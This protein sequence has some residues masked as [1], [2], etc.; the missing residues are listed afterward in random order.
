MIDR[1]MLS[2]RTPL[3]VFTF[4]LVGTIFL[5]ADDKAAQPV[6]GS[7]PAQTMKPQAPPTGDEIHIHWKLIENKPDGSGQRCLWTF[8]NNGKSPLPANGWAIYFCQLNLVGEPIVD[9]NGPFELERLNGDFF[10]ITPKKQF[11]PL[12]PGSEAT[13]GYQGGE[14]VIKECVAPEGIY[15]VYQKGDGPEGKP[16]AIT[17][18]DIEPFTR[19]EQLSRSSKDQTPVPTPGWQYEQ[20]SAL[21]LLPADKVSRI[22]PTP[23]HFESGQGE[24]TLSAKTKIVHG[25]GFKREAVYLAKKLQT[26]FGT[27]PE[28]TAGIEGGADAIMLSVGRVNID[29][30]DR[31][32]GSEAYE[33]SIDPKTG[34]NI[35]GSDD[36]GAFYGIQSLLALLPPQAFAGNQS[37][38]KVGAAKI[39]DAPRF[40]YRGQ[41]LEVC[42]NFHTKQSVLRLL[43]L[44]AFYKLNR[45][46]WHLSDDE[47]WRFEIPGLPELTQYH[48]RRG[49]TLT[50]GE[51]LHPSYGSGPNPAHNHG[52]GYYS[53]ADM[54]EVLRRAHDLHILVIPEIDMPAHS[55]AAIYAMKARERRLET[56]SKLDE[57]REY[58]L[59]DP[60]DKSKYNSA[61]GFQDN[62]ICVAQESSYHFVEKIVQSLVD[63]YRE[64]DVPLIMFHIGGDEVP[65]GAWE[66]SPVCAKFL[67]EHPELKGARDL[68]HYFMTRCNEILKKHGLKAGVWQEAALEP[69]A[70]GRGA[71]LNP[72]ADFAGGQV[73]PYVWNNLSGSEDLCNRLANAGFPVV[74]SSVSN[75]YFDLAYNKDP[76]EPGLVWGGFVDARSPFELVP[77]DVFKST[78]VDSLGRAYTAAELQRSRIS[79]TEEGLKNIIGIQGQIWNETIKGPKM[80]EYYTCPKIIGLAERAWASQPEW[81]KIDEADARHKALDVAWN[82]FA[83]RLGQYELPRLDNL[84][85][86]RDYRLPPPG[87]VVKDG[88]LQANIEYPGL[89]VRYTTNGS[90][91]T[92]ESPLYEKPVS[93]TGAVKIRSFDSRGRGGRVVTI[94]P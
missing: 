74:L 57:A 89:V 36:A 22:T 25:K 66:G 62:V 83:N 78:R 59:H 44:M 76:K 70:G 42:H 91:P 82:E 75:L 29:G 86:G 69:T 77:E 47:G 20:N 92:T 73:T 56:E 34:I 31:P 3:L 40:K 30:K 64:A 51:W 46:H 16:Q 28:V 87:A 67:K 12:A 94:S 79:L 15:I 23:I 32:K 14:P 10:R 35:Q 55:R 88:Q 81:A 45:F 85:G 13:F 33:L 54:I 41:H 49:H 21:S 26:V 43:D 1:L 93:V 17:H 19:P 9:F 37:S 7:K 2:A 61:Q 27:A 52:T 84:L 39:I 58:R 72:Y 5:H 24:L 11:Q 80:L 38:V 18:V 65:H 68:H 8:K 6:V 60:D 71:R 50:S 48:S 53:R 4:L 90:E 63:I